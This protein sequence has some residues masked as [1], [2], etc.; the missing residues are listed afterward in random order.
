MRAKE[1]EEKMFLG[2]KEDID[3]T[4]EYCQAADYIRSLYRTPHWLIMSADYF[5]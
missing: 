4:H 5:C 2:A 3:L 1:K